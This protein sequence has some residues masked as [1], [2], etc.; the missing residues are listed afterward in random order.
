M[1]NPK[2]ALTLM[3]STLVSFPVVAFNETTMPSRCTE[4]VSE[5]QAQFPNDQLKMV[6]S[7]IPYVIS[8]FRE[9]SPI[10][11]AEVFEYPFDMPSPLLPIKS[12]EEMVQRFS[13][14]IDEKLLREIAQ[15][16]V[17]EWSTNGWRGSSL[18]NGLVWVQES[19]GISAIHYETE[20]QKNSI[21]EILAMHKKVLHSSLREF[22][23]PVLTWNSSRF[24]VR[25]DLLEN[26]SYR[27]AV[28]KGGEPQSVE[29]DLVLTNGA[30][31]RTGGSLSY[32]EY[33]FSNGRYNYVVSKAWNPEWPEGKVGELVVSQT[34]SDGT[35]KHLT[36]VDFLEKDAGMKLPVSSAKSR[37]NYVETFINSLLSGKALPEL[38]QTHIDYTSSGS[39]DNPYSEYYCDLK[40]QKVLT[41]IPI[42]HFEDVLKRHLNVS[43]DWEKQQWPQMKL[44][45]SESAGAHSDLVST[46]DAD[47]PVNVVSVK[48]DAPGSTFHFYFVQDVDGDRLVQIS[49]DYLCMA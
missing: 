14:V 34:L 2:S 9:G 6:Q 27:Y 15:T 42:K 11:I 40:F 22:K 48:V 29:P 35:E 12:S 25:I 13:E 21:Q 39:T 5:L 24:N 46:I 20:Q 19:G 3:F 37:K 8:A 30:L 4:G 41:N 26:D 38:G 16:H 33:R 32:P 44:I 28:W 43:F 36:T 7:G 1:I 47:L 45:F 49:D 31:V 18:G 23:E 10:C 17:S